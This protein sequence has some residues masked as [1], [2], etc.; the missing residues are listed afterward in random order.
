MTDVQTNFIHT[1]KKP[2]Y[3][4]KKSKPYNSTEIIYFNN[5]NFICMTISN[6]ENYKNL[7]D[8]TAKNLFDFSHADPLPFI[9]LLYCFQS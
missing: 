6:L 7:V 8:K 2:I 5:Y 4:Q 3:S 9:Y 1:I